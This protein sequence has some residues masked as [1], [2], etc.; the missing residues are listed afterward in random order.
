MNRAL[1]EK[2]GYFWNPIY[3]SMFVD[4]DLYWVCR[5]NNWLNLRPDL[6]FEHHHY[7]VGK[8]EKDYTYIR[9]DKNWDQGKAIYLKRKQS[10]FP[11]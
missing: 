3:K 1:Y 2:L 6:K 4:Q 11:L 7:S 10:N 5:N 9:S 8:S